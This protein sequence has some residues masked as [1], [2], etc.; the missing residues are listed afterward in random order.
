M[1]GPC[2]RGEPS[3]A[4]QPERRA[5]RQSAQTM[6]RAQGLRSVDTE[7]FA[8]D[9]SGEWHRAVASLSP[10]QCSA[11][12]SGLRLRRRLVRV[13]HDSRWTTD[14]R[15]KGEQGH[16]AGERDTGQHDHACSGRAAPL[17]ATVP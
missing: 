13:R 5:D 3:C 10:P 2:E 16:R 12:R 14:G 7:A 4:V 17:C 15:S 11:L 8:V 6:H 1:I 9:V